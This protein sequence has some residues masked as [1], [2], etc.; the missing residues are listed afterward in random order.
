MTTLEARVAQYGCLAPIENADVVRQQMR[1]GARYYNELIALERCRRAVYR[2]L[3]RKYVDLESVEARVEELAAELMSLREAIKGVRKEAR[4]RV[5]TA[6]L[7]QRAKDVQSALRVA[8][9][10][11]KDARQAAR[12]NAE[13]RAAVEQLD[14]RAKIWSKALRAMRAPWWGTYLLEEASAEQARKATIDPSFRRAR[15]RERISAAG[16]GSAEGRIGVQVQGGMTVAELYGCED[17]RLRIEPVS[18]DAWHASSR[19]VRRRCSRTR[20]WMRVESAGRSPVWAVFPLILH[21]PI[22][23]DARI[24]GAVVRLRVLGFREQWTVSVTYARE[25][26]VMPERPG[27]VALDLGWRQRPDGSLRVAYCAD[28]QGNHREVVMPES[29]RMR[30]RKARDLREIQDLHFNRAVRWLARWLDAGKAPE[31]LARERPHLGQWR[32]HGRLRRLVLDWRRTR[33]VGDERIFAAMERWLHRSR[34]LYQWEVDAQR[35]ALLARREL[36]RCTAAQIARAYGRVVIEQFDLATA[37]RL[38]AP[39]QGED[40]PLAQ[41]AQLHA[42]APGEFRQCLTQAVQREGGLVISV[43]ASGTTSHCHACGGVCSWEQGEELWH[44]CEYCGELWDQDH[45]AA[46]NLLRRF[47]R[48][49]SGDATN[50]APARKPSKRAERFRK[51]HA[52]PAATDVA[53]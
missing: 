40:A 37:K 3:R 11:L 53:E 14:E 24:K 30:L 45:N 47:T 32:S 29:V 41:R 20:L 27:I 43:D 23:D 15:G 34:H 16:E 46:I 50:P 25:P 35:K 19:G 48:D 8:R 39:E 22:P 36:Y 2:D 5:D 33:F 49:H 12:D 51:R 13:L 38:K 18:P 21:R 42:S 4:R 1:L 52:Q 31:W 17:T 7:D 28:D 44:R 26:A 10:A 9:V 6:D